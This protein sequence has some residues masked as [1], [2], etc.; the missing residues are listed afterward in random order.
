MLYYNCEETIYYGA[1]MD[2]LQ[3]FLG[4]Y[5]LK[6]HNKTYNITLRDFLYQYSSILRGNGNELFPEEEGNWKYDSSNQTL[7]FNVWRKRNKNLGLIKTTKVR[8]SFKVIEGENLTF[9][10]DIYQLKKVN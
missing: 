9:E 5:E 8:Y 6:K 3:R 1:K 10:S 2:G 4:N 7:Y